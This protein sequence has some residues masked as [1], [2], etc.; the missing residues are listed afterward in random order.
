[1]IL[2]G[3]QYQQIEVSTKISKTTYIRTKA[4]FSVMH[5]RFSFRARTSGDVIIKHHTNIRTSSIFLKKNKKKLKTTSKM[6]VFTLTFT[7]DISKRKLLYKLAQE[8]KNSQQ[9]LPLV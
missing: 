3:Q 6:N 8:L 4:G 5:E 7:S 1:M 2:Q 9:L